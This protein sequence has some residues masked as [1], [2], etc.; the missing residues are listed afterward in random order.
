VSEEVQEGRPIFA[1]GPVWR[2]LEHM[3]G[4]RIV[5]E[6]SRTDVVFRGEPLVSGC[7]CRDYVSG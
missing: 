3:K 2:S 1:L 5:F 7:S 6:P 4:I